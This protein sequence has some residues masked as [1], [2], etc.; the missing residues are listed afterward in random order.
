MVV[1][2][3]LQSLS[4]TVTSL[5]REA[6]RDEVLDSVILCIETSFKSRLATSLFPEVPRHSEKS[7]C[8][9][10]ANQGREIDLLGSQG[11]EY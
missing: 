4:F 10:E 8:R 7:V 2:R 1:A 3:L 9:T 5:D 6:E 11:H